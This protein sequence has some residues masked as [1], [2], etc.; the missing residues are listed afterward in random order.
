MLTDVIAVQAGHVEEPVAR[1]DA[2]GRPEQNHE[3][4]EL[5]VAQ[6]HGLATGVPRRRVLTSKR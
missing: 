3:E 6:R 4:T 2:I 1:Q 5:A